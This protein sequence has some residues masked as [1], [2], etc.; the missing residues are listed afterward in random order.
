MVGNIGS[1]ERLQ[2]TAIGDAVN[3]AS[4]LEGLNKEFATQIIIS[5]ETK[6]KLKQN[7]N[8]KNLGSVSIKG[9]KDK[10]VIYS[11]DSTH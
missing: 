3:T 2:Y 5:E 11:I 4:R 1:S 8:F 9:K 6:N 7:Y 10:V